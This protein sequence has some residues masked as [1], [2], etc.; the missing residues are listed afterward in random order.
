MF[1]KDF[2]SASKVR[3]TTLIFFSFNSFFLT[4]SNDNKE[5]I[6]KNKNV[7]YLSKMSNGSKENPIFASK[8]VQ[9]FTHYT[10]I[11]ADLRENIKM[12]SIKD[13]SYSILPIVDQV[14]EK[15][16]GIVRVLITNNSGHPI[17]LSLK[18]SLIG[19][20]SDLSKKGKSTKLETITILPREVWFRDISFVSDIK[21]GKNYFKLIFNQ[22]REEYA[23][24]HIE[25]SQI[26]E[27]EDQKQIERSNYLGMLSKAF[28][29]PHSLNYWLYYSIF[30]PYKYRKEPVFLQI[31]KGFGVI[32]GGLLFILSFPFATTLT[33]LPDYLMPVGA[34]IALI[35]L[36]SFLSNLDA[37]KVKLIKELELTDQDR[38][39]ALEFTF[40]T[41]AGTLSKFTRTDIN[42]SYNP[43]KNTIHWKEG[44]NKLYQRL[45]PDIGNMI[46]LSTEIKG[47]LQPK[48]EVE[49]IEDRDELKKKISKG[50][51]LQH[52][53]GIRLKGEIEAVAREAQGVDI[54]T[55]TLESDTSIQEDYDSIKT[56]ADIKQEIDPI[57]TVPEI[58]Q[59]IEPIEA[60]PDIEQKIEPI[61]SDTS[62]DKE[63]V[64]IKTESK[65]VVDD[66][67][68]YI[69]EVTD[70]E[71]IPIPKNIPGHEF[72]SK[73][74]KSV[75]ELDKEE[76]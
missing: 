38:T 5:N 53:E 13:I 42:F 57:K 32:S 75:K 54:V 31:L 35:S 9:K 46:G 74:K 25:Y 3:C 70:V 71:T 15:G 23:S 29:D 2:Y 44:A 67:R 21:Q 41:I 73:D 30:G 63:I 1:L 22:K 34:L 52:E 40:N 39:G 33:S 36:L 56:S 28:I 45:I 14:P 66:A 37:K 17:S 47:T 60:K 49:V 65:A 10:D 69:G 19:W 64:P 4:I 62:I 24:T 16:R 18:Y 6:I 11:D 59:D 7:T 12:E 61:I 26:R 27:I 43:E 68:G 51:E 55:D 72:K 20:Y 50:I 8:F 58:K 48:S 76:D